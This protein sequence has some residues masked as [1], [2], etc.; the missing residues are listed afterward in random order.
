MAC[1]GQESIASWQLQV[2]HWPGPITWD[3]SLT[4]S[5]TRGQTAAQL[6]QPIQVSSSTTGTFAMKAPS[7]YQLK[8]L[9]E[10][11]HLHT[12]IDAF[13]AVHAGI[14]IL[15]FKMGRKFLGA[16]LEF[17]DIGVLVL[18]KIK[19]GSDAVFPDLRIHLH[20]L[21]F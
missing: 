2:P 10:L 1:T 18:V 8:V 20:N 15:F 7:L 13:D 16:F 11:P 19:A 12:E 14:G 4:I 5:N 21:V 6:P 17:N 9:D 3:F